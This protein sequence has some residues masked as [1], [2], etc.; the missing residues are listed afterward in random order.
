M[1]EGYAICLNQWALDKEIKNEL[2]LLLIISSL[3]AEK[4]Y[5]YSGNNYFAELFEIDESMVSKKIKKL[6][7]K[8]YIKIEYS[9][10]GNVVSSRI[11]RLSKMTKPLSKMTTAVVKND[12]EN[13]TS[14]NKKETNNINI[15]SKERNSNRFKK[16]TKS[17]IDTYAR[18]NN[19]LIDSEYFIDYYESK[20]WLVG[21][22]PMKNWKS[23]VRNWCRN[24]NKYETTPR[25]ETSNPHFEWVNEGGSMTLK[26]VE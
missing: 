11:I 15:I 3:C 21:K 1:D 12:K 25:N 7:S 4:G 2:G 17:D 6:E 16:P 23:A 10:V 9:K 20:G 5:C 19:L 18:E 8:G 26:R 14:I 24:N 13:I 22:S